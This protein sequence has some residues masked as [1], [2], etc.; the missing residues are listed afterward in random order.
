MNNSM[1]FHGVHD[2]DYNTGGLLYPAGT[3]LIFREETHDPSGE[4]SPA[5]G[6]YRSSNKYSVVQVTTLL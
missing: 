2:D 3:D 4:F 5:L 1:A 6:A